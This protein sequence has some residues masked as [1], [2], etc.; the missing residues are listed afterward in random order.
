MK[1][2]HAS[3]RESGRAAGGLVVRIFLHVRQSSLSENVW[4]GCISSDVK[5]SVP[6]LVSTIQHLAHVPK[7]ALI[8]DLIRRDPAERAIR[9]L[10]VSIPRIARQLVAEDA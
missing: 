6:H 1:V 5:D 9:I 8:L 10:P 3:K 4:S 2:L 7:V